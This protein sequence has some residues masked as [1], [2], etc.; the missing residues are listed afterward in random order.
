[1]FGEKSISLGEAPA[2][3][4]AGQARN[5]DQRAAEKDN[6]AA[7]PHTSSNRKRLTSVSASRWST[8]A[9]VR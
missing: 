8:M 1:M 5:Q 4:K 3:A 9:M 7:T 6:C 2:R